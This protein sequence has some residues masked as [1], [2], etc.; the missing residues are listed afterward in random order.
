MKR[1]R[2]AWSRAL[3]LISLLLG[4]CRGTARD[5]YVPYVSGA[6]SVVYT[7]P[8]SSYLNDHTLAR[9]PDGTWHL[10]GTT[11]ASQAAPGKE[12]DL[13]HAVAPSLLGP[14]TSRDPILRLR[15]DLHEAVL[16]APYVFEQHPGAWVMLYWGG[17]NS[18]NPADGS[19]G[20]RRARSAD[21]STWE[22]LERSTDPA[23]YLPGGR[24]PFVLRVNGSFLLYSVS[25]DAQLHG[26][27]V[28]SISDDLLGKAW[29]EPSPVLTD[30]VA[31]FDWG[32]LESPCVVPYGG[33]YYLFVTRSGRGPIDYVRTNVFRSRDPTHFTWQPIADLRAHAAEIIFDAGRYY[34]T[35]SG[36]TS[37]VGEE[38]RG[39][40][41]APLQWASQTR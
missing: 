12:D 39:L 7:P 9:G 29:S 5:D 30:P 2:A 32:N 11:N 10:Y 8:G 35:S 15:T 36:W 18:P 26:Q 24:D 27:I 17:W 22:R 3:A 31:S 21:L 25:V 20:L 23:D 28:V 1:R 33:Q 19:R 34:I 38:N 37:A 40:S 16:W 4:G 41:I 14:W 6:F 13:L